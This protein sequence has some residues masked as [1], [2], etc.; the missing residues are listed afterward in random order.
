MDPFKS[1]FDGGLGTLDP[2]TRQ[3][4][5]YPAKPGPWDGAFTIAIQARNVA[6]AFRAIAA[7]S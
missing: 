4:L 2:M 7:R 3:L 5:G 6:S 1:I